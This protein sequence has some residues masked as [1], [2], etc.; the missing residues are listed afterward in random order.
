MAARLLRIPN[1][2]LTS[3]LLGNMTVNVLYFATA[4]VLSVNLARS[5]HPAAA[6]IIGAVSFMLLLL[7]GE[8]LPKSLAWSNSTRFC[9]AA[10]PVCY[11]FVRL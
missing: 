4:S 6:G 5:I 7:F 11:V 3:I 2:L 10:T 8:M 1:R 9:L